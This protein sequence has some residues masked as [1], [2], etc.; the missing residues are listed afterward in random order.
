MHGLAKIMISVFFSLKVKIRIKWIVL[1]S[2]FMRN[3]K[4]LEL[5]T[6]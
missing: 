3:Y 1:F 4:E 5:I 6:K 2:Q